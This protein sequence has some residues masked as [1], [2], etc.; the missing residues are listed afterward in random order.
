MKRIQKRIIICWIS[1]NDR[2][3]EDRASVIPIIVRLIGEIL[4]LAG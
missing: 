2:R 3:I 1:A 4:L